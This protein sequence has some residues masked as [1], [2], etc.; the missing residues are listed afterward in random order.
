MYMY[1]YMY[2]LTNNYIAISIGQIRYQ[3]LAVLSQGMRVK[4]QLCPSC[5]GIGF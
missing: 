2:N 1:L 3:S 4:L 5:V